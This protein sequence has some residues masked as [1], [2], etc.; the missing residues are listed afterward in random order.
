MQNCFCKDFVAIAILS[1]TF[2]CKYK[3]CTAQFGQSQAKPHNIPNFLKLISA[4]MRVYKL[5]GTLS[6]CTYKII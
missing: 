4:R 3:K 6:P 1:N 5:V 2:V